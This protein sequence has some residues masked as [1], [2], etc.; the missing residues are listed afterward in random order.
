MVIKRILLG[1]GSAILLSGCATSYQSNGFTGGYSETRLAP[2]VFRVV[3]NG[4]GYTSGERAQ[5]F[6]LLRASDLT[7][8]GG[9]SYFA[10]IDEKNS[11]S[12]SSFTTPGHAQTTAYG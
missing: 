3:F 1:V 11:T 2:D 9:C 7:I 12:T 4:N 10:I 5:D 8:Q 6:A